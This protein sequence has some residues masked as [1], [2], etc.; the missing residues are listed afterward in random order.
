MSLGINSVIEIA[1]EKSYLMYAGAYCGPYPTS[2]LQSFAVHAVVTPQNGTF[3]FCDSIDNFY[4][5]QIGSARESQNSEQ[6]LKYIVPTPNQNSLEFQV[7]HRNDDK[8]EFTARGFRANGQ[9]LTKVSEYLPNIGDRKT[10]VVKDEND[11]V[12]FNIDIRNN[13]YHLNDSKTIYAYARIY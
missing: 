11:N 7:A 9:Y 12:K 2:W 8:L 13:G 1:N 6:P 4:F 10:I 5:Y 3:T